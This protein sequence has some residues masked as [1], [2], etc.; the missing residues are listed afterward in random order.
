[1]PFQGTLYLH[2]FHVLNLNTTVKE[3]TLMD[4]VNAMTYKVGIVTQM[5]FTCDRKGFA[6]TVE[7]VY[8]NLTESFQSNQSILLADLLW[9][10]P[11]PHILVC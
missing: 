4:M 5:P 7:K 2:M 8:I 11:G 6:A 1:M 10:G 3:D 9:H